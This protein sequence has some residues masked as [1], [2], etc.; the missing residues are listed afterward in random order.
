[1]KIHT[2]LAITL[3]ACTTAISSIHAQSKQSPVDLQADQ[4]QHDDSTQRVT[5][6]GNVILKQDGK[7]VKAD[8]I[9]YILNEDRVI[10]TGNV[11]FMDITGD[12]HKASSVEFSDTLKSGFIEEL[13]SILVDGSRITASNGQHLDGTRTVMKDVFYTPCKICEEKPEKAPLWQLRA[14]EVEHNKETKT[15]KYRN[16]RLEVKGVPV[17]WLPYFSH[18]DGTVERKSG[19][20][21]PAAGFSSDLGVFVEG[22][23]YWSLA[24]D[25]D[26]TAGIRAY[27]DENPLGF[28]EYRQRWNNASLFVNGNFT[29]SDRNDI[30]NDITIEEENELRGNLIVSGL[31]DINNKWRSGLKINIASD[32]Q[33]LRQYDFDTESE[34]TS[35]DDVLENQLF[36][37]RFSGRNYFVSRLLAFQDVRAEEDLEESQ[38]FVLPEI[39]A[40]FLGEPGAIPFLGGRYDIQAS[41]LS[42]LRDESNEQ[43]VVRGH[44]SAGWQRRIVSDYGLVS[45]VNANVQGTVF[46]VNDRLG[47]SEDSTI[48]ASSF[49]GRAFGYLDIKASY[50]LAKRFKS[51][52][53]IIEPVASLTL[54][55][56]VGDD[57]EI[58]NEDSLDVQLGALNLFEADR[59]AGVDRVEDQSRITYGVRT[60]VYSDDGSFGEAFLGQSFRFDNDGSDFTSGSGL[61]DQS[62]D[63]VGE[64]RANYKNDYSLNYR[65]QL[66]NDSLAS[67]RHEVGASANIYN[68]RLSSRYL[69]ASALEGT[70]IDASREQIVNSASYR[71][72]DNWRVF[73]SA[74]HDLGEDPGLRRAFLGLDFTGDCVTWSL[75][76]ERNLTNESSGDNST[77]I[78]LRLGL[79]NLGEF[80][81]SGLDVGSGQ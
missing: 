41:F 76:A 46:H 62:S 69:F 33:F 59:F 30:E 3:L 78:F 12:V 80:A 21:S 75:A 72:N 60:G 44:L 58:P 55:P 77:E 7:T 64:V 26:L 65:F 51:S 47:A 81:T 25:K 15:I 16:A 27:T 32:D 24:P 36:A 1:M 5:A 20:L 40:Q 67:V 45:E 13:Q 53:V 28:L 61:D 52:Q 66:D 6:S 29:V 71:I 17:A 43:D 57:S 22:S 9:I 54:A 74:R 49:E 11:E 8:E 48:D 37:E 2:R 63:I 34:T 70:E 42:L 23:Y 10:A 73:G 19:F 56:N 39:E 18:T 79:K 35:D 50:P 14:S 38:P 31:W 4:L 68:L